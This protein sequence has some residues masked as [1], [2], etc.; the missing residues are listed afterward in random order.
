[1][2]KLGYLVIAATLVM[3]LPAAAGS[4]KSRT[5][6]GEYNTVTLTTDPDP[7]VA[8]RFSNGVRF[9]TLPKE[10]YVSLTIA[11]EVA[12]N[13]R[14]MVGQD[15]DGDGVDDE[16]TEICNTTEAPIK[17]TP[18]IPLTVWTQEGT[19]ADGSPSTPTSGTIE[20]MFMTK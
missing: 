15:I 5:E 14:A 8:G 4:S 13:V 11:D 19:C 9:E 12:D 7:V 10:K 3:A 18:G 2:K 20:A 6:S 17:I 16:I 1:M